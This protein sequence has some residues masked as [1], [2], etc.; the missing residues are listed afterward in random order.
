MK[1]LE[2]SIIQTLTYFDLFDHPLTEEELFRLLWQPPEGLE[3]GFFLEQ[4]KTFEESL[5]IENSQGFWYLKG[6]KSIL[7]HRQSR[8]KL[9]EEKMKIAN[10]GIKKL[11]WIP[12]VRSVFVCNTV[13]SAI[14]DSDSDIDVFIVVRKNRLWLTRML[15]TL[16]LSLFGLRRTKKKIKNKICLS[17]YVTDDKLNLKQVTIGESDIYLIYWIAQLIPLYDPD[18]LL[19]SIQKANTWVKSYV[20]HVFQ[21][22]K[23]LSRMRIEDTVLSGKVKRGF[24][25]MW[26]SG[27]GAVLEKQARS[28]QLSKMKHNIKSVQNQGDSRVVINDSMLKFHENDRRTEY[29]EVWQKK[30]NLI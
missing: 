6:R 5:Y 24:E 28:L 13:A 18:N 17:F 19:L 29:R 12:F 1:D 21:P 3:Y 10:R 14:A 30:C 8:I 4:L 22:Y 20:P 11:R 23:L 7:G 2:T 9:V 15:V 25:R 26:G 27:Y 16:S